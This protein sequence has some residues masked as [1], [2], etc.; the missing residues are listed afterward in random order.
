MLT[1]RQSPSVMNTGK[2]QRGR[3]AN[4]YITHEATS[5]RDKQREERH[6][7]GNR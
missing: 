3:T 7:K 1:K 5:V 2:A 6:I 4:S